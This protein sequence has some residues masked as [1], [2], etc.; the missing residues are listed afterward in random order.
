MFEWK[1]DSRSFAGTSP[2][3]EPARGLGRIRRAPSTEVI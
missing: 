3:K 1:A 2:E